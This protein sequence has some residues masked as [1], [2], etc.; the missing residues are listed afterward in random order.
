MLR[1]GIIFGII[2]FVLTLI[3]SNGVCAV[4]FAIIL[5]LGA[6]YTAANSDRPLDSSESTRVGAGAGAL[7][8]GLM[9]PAQLIAAAIQAGGGELPGGSVTY[10]LIGPAGAEP[11]VIWISQL[12]I[13]CC[14]GI[15]TL[16]ITAGAGV[17]GSALWFRRRRKSELDE[18]IPP[19]I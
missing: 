4:C 6:G 16:A 19:A 14:L 17:A 9:I 11:A 15:I 8:G 1:A 3:S 18:P 2:A 7:A 5:G 13:G 10:E 12:L